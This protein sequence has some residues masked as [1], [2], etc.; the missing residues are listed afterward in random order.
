MHKIDNILNELLAFDSSLEQNKE[1]LKDVINQMYQI[2]PVVKI[3]TE[4][5]QKLKHDLHQK[6][7]EEKI[8]SKWK[9][10][11]IYKILFWAFW[12]VATF[13]FW[14][15]FFNDTIKYVHA[16]VNTD[17]WKKDNLI[18]LRMSSL[19]ETEN[20]E[21]KDILENNISNDLIE[22]TPNKIVLKE[23]LNVKTLPIETV[24]PKTWSVKKE[25][26][27]K[28]A[29]EVENINIENTNITDSNVDNIE[30]ST[31]SVQSDMINKDNNLES[32]Q[33]Q[34]TISNDDNVDNN[35]WLDTVSWMMLQTKAPTMAK[36]S[37]SFQY[38]LDT[39]LDTE[40]QKIEIDNTI[41]ET[42]TQNI[43]KILNF[44]SYLLTNDTVLNFDSIYLNNW[45]YFINFLTSNNDIIEISLNKSL[46]IYDENNLIIQKK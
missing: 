30:V 37:A 45:E 40:F 11:N 32:T 1:D 42:N 21:N 6:I 26:Q 38:L 22:N 46:Y 12:V 5:R 35:E 28:I 14:F 15:I 31:F 29:D 24:K 16:P 44:E 43:V 19:P 3:D 4:F 10:K 17:E 41:F 2:K 27:S 20:I 9:I 18:W 8:T 7:L 36:Q 25:T 23:N 39:N 33:I 13:V 34:D